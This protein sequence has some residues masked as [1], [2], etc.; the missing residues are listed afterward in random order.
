LGVYDSQAY[1]ASNHGGTVT[2]GGTFNSAGTY[3]E[4]S[5]IGGMKSNTTDGNVSGDINFYTR[6][7]SSAMT[8]RMRITSGGNVCMGIATSPTDGATLTVSPVSGSN[9]GQIS[10]I[11][12][13]SAGNPKL[14]LE[15][16]GVNG[17]GMFY[18]RSA[19]L[20]KVW[21]GTETNGVSMTSFATS[22]SSYSD[23]RLKTDL[24]P[25]DNALDKI[26]NIRPFTGRYKTDEEGVSRSFLIAQDIINVF[27]EAIHE[28]EDEEKTLSLRYTDMIPLM[29]KAI[30][31]QQSQ[32]ESL[33]AEIQTLKQ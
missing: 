12:G 26:K 18:D 25:I 19:G 30:Q 32:I 33:K 11:G 24:V 23:E 29:M 10:I 17:A 22:W 16:P 20:L 2:F 13:P 31:E 9:T 15:A 27:P 3:T 1:N 4:W 14:Y 21:V 5:S 6:L 7:D 28:S 8:E